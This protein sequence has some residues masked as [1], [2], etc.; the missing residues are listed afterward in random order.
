MFNVWLRHV[1]ASVNLFK[2]DALNYFRFGALATR[3]KN[4]D[5]CGGKILKRAAVY[6][7]RLNHDRALRNCPGTSQ[8]S[9]RG[10]GFGDLDF[11]KRETAFLPCDRD[12]CTGKNVFSRGG[13]IDLLYV[14]NRPRIIDCA[15]RQQQDRQQHRKTNT[16]HS[17]TSASVLSILQFTLAALLRFDQTQNCNRVLLMECL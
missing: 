13:G 1:S 5:F 3:P 10:A 8:R 11:W 15:R 14:R 12:P 4:R 9:T 7:S 6:H 2:F 16:G 17:V